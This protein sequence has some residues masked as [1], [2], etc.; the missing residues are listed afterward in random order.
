M[1]RLPPALPESVLRQTIAAFNEHISSLY[2]VVGDQTYVMF[3][4]TDGF[5]ELL[6]AIDE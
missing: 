5:G 2:F 4:K 1:R 6:V 3:A